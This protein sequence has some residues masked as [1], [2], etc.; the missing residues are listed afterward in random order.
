MM[1]TYKQLPVIENPLPVTEI[2]CA[3]TE[4]ID[5]DIPFITIPVLL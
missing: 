3:F 4:T 2:F 1:T 5:E